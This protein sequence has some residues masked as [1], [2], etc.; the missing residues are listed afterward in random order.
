[1]TVLLCYDGS[2]DA[3]AAIARAG[4]LFPGSGAIVLHVSKSKIDW[5]FGP[6]L[7]PL[8]DIPG[9]D[10]AIIAQARAVLDEGVELAR[11]AGFQV[12]GELR[13]TGSAVWRTVIEV[14]EEHHPEVIVA[15][16]HGTRLR[17]V[18]PL[19]SVARGLVAHATT[20]LLITHRADRPSPDRARPTVLVGYDGSDASNLALDTATQRFPDAS[21]EIVCAW[22]HPIALGLGTDAAWAAV[23]DVHDA[24]QAEAERVAAVGAERAS[25]AGVDVASRTLAASAGVGT[26]LVEAAHDVGA[27]LIGLGTHG[28]GALARTILGSTAQ[29]VVQNADLPVLVVPPVSDSAD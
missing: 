10:E 25:R 3:R 18:L 15:G 7:G 2:D 21:F 17:D 6:A 5:T 28:H 19:G 22:E 23:Q 14:A 1:M 16:S 13:T 24:L 20:P 29:W 12:Q 11:E 26:A 27:A 4:E 9:V 8:L